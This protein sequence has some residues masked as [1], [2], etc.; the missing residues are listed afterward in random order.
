VFINTS[1]GFANNY[2]E[3]AYVKN[4]DK[5]YLFFNDFRENIQ[6]LQNTKGPKQIVVVKDCDAFYFPLTGNE[7][8]HPVNIFWETDEKKNIFNRH[9]VFLYFDKRMMFL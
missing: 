8:Y 5:A 4:N 6:R 3:Y 9:L 7:Y 1:G 2:I